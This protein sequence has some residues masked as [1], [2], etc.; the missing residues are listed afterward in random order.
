MFRAC[1]RAMD[2]A[3]LK[4]QLDEPEVP[5]SDNPARDAFRAKMR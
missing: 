3:F 4:S 5:E 1:I 2:A